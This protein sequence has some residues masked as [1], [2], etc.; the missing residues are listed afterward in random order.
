MRDECLGQNVRK[1]GS[2]VAPFIA[3][4]RDYKNETYLKPT[5]IIVRLDSNDTLRIDI[6]HDTLIIDSSYNLSIDSNDISRNENRHVQ[7]AIL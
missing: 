5:V 7:I 6:S 2:R 4:S 1:D 3:S